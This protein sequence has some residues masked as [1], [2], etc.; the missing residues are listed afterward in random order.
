MQCMLK[1][2][3]KLNVP[4]ADAVKRC[5]PGEVYEYEV[6][7]EEYV[8]RLAK[9]SISVPEK[10]FMACF[11]PIHWEVR[12]FS[13]DGEA[14]ALACGPKETMPDAK[15]RKLYRLHGYK[16]YADGKPLKE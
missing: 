9:S 14:A 5:K 13:I 11:T 15:Q 16:I 8:I 7:G 3:G 12:G 4:G 10:V 2:N 1:N 6:V